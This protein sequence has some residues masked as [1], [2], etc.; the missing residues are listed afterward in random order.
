MR[1]KDLKPA[2]LL[3]LVEGLALAAIFAGLTLGQ[4]D[5]RDV[6]LTRGPY[7]Q[8]VTTDGIVIVWETNIAAD[9]RLDFG[10]ASSQGASAADPTLTTHHAI[11]LTGL[12]PY[13]LYRYQVWSNDV[14]LG[15]ES[16]FRTAAP[17]DQAAFSF[18]VLG[19]TRYNHAAHQS[20]ADCIAQLGP[21]FALHMGDLVQAGGDA[22]DW[23]MFFSVE[24]NLLHQTSLF[25]VLGNHENNHPNYLDAFHLPNNERW[26]SFD[27]GHAHF[28][29]LQVDG[30][31]SFVP[32]SPQ[33][34][35]L[36][37][38]LA[39][40]DKEWKVVALHIPPYSSGP[41][42][43]YGD[44]PVAQAV[45]PP[46]FERYGVDVVFS[47]H[48]HDY[49]RSL[50]SGITY[51]VS[52]GG[53]APLYEQ[54]NPNPYSLYFTSTLHTVLVTINDDTLSAIGVRPDGVLFDPFTVT[55]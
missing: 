4:A 3:A 54:T 1:L 41:N 33:Y 34:A 11:A 10:L 5:A 26:Y 48:D 22:S 52:G 17:A 21:D 49:E 36:E 55:R 29:A 16:T 35:W 30:Y 18:A 12:L 43:P 25:P 32:G 28:V 44:A 40:S 15:Q 37:N 20:V 50:V 38:D 45:L 27:Y 46:L 13:T 23:D 53:G 31:A 24:G 19:D 14:P 2:V 7:L 47:G 39:S 6:A 8:S 9:S 42:A 51:V